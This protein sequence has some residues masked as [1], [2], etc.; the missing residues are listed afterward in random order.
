MVFDPLPT[1]EQVLAALTPL[2][3]EERLAPLLGL[4]EDAPR[5]VF[6]PS[7]LEWFPQCNNVWPHRRRLRLR[8]IRAGNAYPYQSE[9]ERKLLDGFD[10]EQQ[11][12]RGCT[13]RH[14]KGLSWSLDYDRADAHARRHRAM[15]G[16]GDVYDTMIPRRDILAAITTRNET[17]VLLDYIRLTDIQ[18]IVG[19][20]RPLRTEFDR[21]TAGTRKNKLPPIENMTDENLEAMLA[22]KLEHLRTA[23]LLLRITSLKA[24]IER[25]RAE[26][27]KRKAGAKPGR[28]I[29]KC[30][31]KGAAATHEYDWKQRGRSQGRPTAASRNVTLPVHAR[32]SAS[33]DDH[34]ALL[35]DEAA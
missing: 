4:L 32:P 7:F 10:A 17:F 6:Y 8:L 19:G 33:N 24:D 31:E 11:V 13:T 2:A 21:L 9:S 23:Q 28:K 30:P 3:P 22:Q 25:A 16:S 5:D 26:I 1:P 18:R 15:A 29:K 12:F 34:R 35:D 14:R 20:T 27:A